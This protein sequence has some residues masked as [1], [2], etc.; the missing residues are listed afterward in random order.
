ML[1]AFWWLLTVEAIGIAAFPIAYALLPRLRDRGY[2]VTKPLG[3][4]ILGYLAWILSV[5]HI[6]PSVRVS[7]ALLLLAMGAA[8]A[9][10]RVAPPRGAEGLRSSGVEDN[11]RRGGRVPG[12]FHRLGYLPGL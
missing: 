11:R 4:L 8:S 2:S 5:L 1:N 10:V 9:W 6:V 12:L 3:I 7:I